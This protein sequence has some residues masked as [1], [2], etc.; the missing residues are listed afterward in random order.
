MLPLGCETG[1]TMATEYATLITVTL[2]TALEPVS[3]EVCLL[4]KVKH[5]PQNS[6]DRPAAMRLAIHHHTRPSLSHGGMPGAA[7]NSTRSV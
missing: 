3:L 4:R 2:Q 6:D 7:T 5:R 1:S